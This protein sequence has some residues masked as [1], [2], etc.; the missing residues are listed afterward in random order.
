VAVVGVAGRGEADGAAVGLQYRG[1]AVDAQEGA[2]RD[3]EVGVRVVENG[4]VGHQ[5]DVDG[6]VLV[7]VGTV[8]HRHR[9]V[10][11]RRH[12]DRGRGFAVRLVGPVAGLFP[13]RRSSD[14]VAVV[15]VAGR[16][17]ADGAAVGLQ[18]RGP[19]VDAQ[20]G[21]DRDVEVGVRVV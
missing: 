1:P 6:G 14:L 20:E 8:V 21:A 18:Y 7:G 10:V 11:D 19:A 5:I 17:E 13:S 2:D 4:N 9:G 12:V 16:G 3:V 15:G